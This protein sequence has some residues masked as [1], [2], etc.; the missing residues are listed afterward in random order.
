MTGSLFLVDL[1]ITTVL[2]DVLS[3][4]VFDKKHTLSTFLLMP[5]CSSLCTALLGGS[6]LCILI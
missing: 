5:G 6:V 1:G 3:F 2:M 4:F